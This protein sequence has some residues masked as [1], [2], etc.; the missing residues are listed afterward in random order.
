MLP[1]QQV[2]SIYFHLYTDSLK[3]GTHNYINVDAKL[4]DG[5]WLPLTAKQLTFTTSAGIFE[6][7][8]LI[9]DKDFTGE[10]ITVSAVLKNDA[11]I[12]RSI[13][14]YIK[15]NE[16]NERLKTTEEIMNEVKNPRKKK[17]PA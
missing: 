1:A 3:K 15:K 2:D 9:L 12:S 7:N 5:R 8:D 11:A 6:N 4:A 13:T 17:K 10:K 16:D 14:I